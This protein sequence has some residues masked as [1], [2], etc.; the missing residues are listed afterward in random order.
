MRPRTAKV[1]FAWGRYL[2][3]DRFSSDEHYDINPVLVKVM[4]A[5]IRVGWMLR[6]LIGLWT[7]ITIGLNLQA[8]T[9][10]MDPYLKLELQASN[11]HQGFRLRWPSETGTIYQVQSAP[12]LSESNWM[13]LATPLTATDDF[14]CL[15][16]SAP[17]LPQQFYR[18]TKTARVLFQ[19]D[20]NSG[21]SD[22]WSLAPG[23]SMELDGDNSILN[24]EGHV[25]ANL[26]QTYNWN[27]FRLQF[28]L[29][30]ITGNLHVNYRSCNV[31]R[32]FVWF[33]QSGIM[34]SKQYWPDVFLN[35]LQISKTP[36]P[37]GIWQSI[38]I[39]GS[40]PNIKVLVNGETRIDF[41]D[42]SPLLNGTIAFESLSGRVQI[43]DVLVLGP[44]PLRSYPRLTWVRTGGPLG[45]IGYD[46]RIDPTNTKI[47]YVTDA[48]SGVSKSWDGGA[49]WSP[50]NDGIIS[51]GG[52]SGDAIPVFCL[53]IDPHHSQVLWIG[54][55]SMRGV[56]KST[57][58]GALWVEKDDGIADIPGITFRSF[59]VHPTNSDI[60]YLG[61]E[62]PTTNLGPDGQNLVFGKIFKT[63]DGGNHWEEILAC[64]ALVRWII[65]DPT[66]TRILYAATGIF[67]RDDVSSEGILKSTDAGHTWRAIN[68]GLG[69]LTVGALVM[70]PSDP[71][72]LYA[73]T[74]RNDGFGGGPT[75]HQGGV[76]KSIDGGE[77][78][79]KIL[80]LGDEFFVVTGLALAPSNPDFLYAAPENFTSYR[81]MDAG[82]TWQAFPFYADGTCLGAPI[83]VTF[84]P[85]DASIVYINSYVGGVF[86]SVDGGENWHIS[87]QGYTGAQIY[88]VSIDPLH[89]MTIYANGRQG[90]AK[91]LSGGA[92]WTYQN[93]N[94]ESGIFTE[95]A[96]VSVNPI[97]SQD[98]VISHRF[99]GGVY[100]SLDGGTNWQ[101]VFYE[102]LVAGQHGISHFARFQRNPKIIYGASKIAELTLTPQFTKSIGIIKSIDGGNNWSKVTN[103][104]IA[105]FNFNTVALH[106][107]NP[108][109][110]Y[111][112]AHNGGVYKTTDGGANWQ[113]VGGDFATDIRSMAVDP[114]DG[115]HIYAG[116]ERGGLFVSKNA[117]VSWN[118][119]GAGIDA[120]ASIRSIVVDPSNSEI[121]WAGD[122]FSGVYYSMDRGASWILANNGLRT[123]AVTALSISA[124]GKVLYA[125]T[126]GEGVFRLGVL[127]P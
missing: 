112:G 21:N 108:D 117:G 90:F 30:I 97:D 42:S 78:W 109:I 15:P 56:Y 89:P 75:A 96:A 1:Y 27:D 44:P 113:Q 93:R 58:G 6:W 4:K 63:M 28:R 10:P 86:K 60:V 40:G 68:Q 115:E 126:D 72:V 17:V 19:D 45:G 51:R 34:I 99:N 25:W 46:L 92:D 16:V 12:Q 54:T 82:K 66:D 110:V 102:P 52:A 37:T 8:E 88:D 84:D 70:D 3:C 39:M 55:L 71:K 116:I 103:G 74:G 57:N 2:R 120:N 94:Q 105:D 62:I 53:T 22:Q 33:D 20:F 123:R 32:Y 81:S 24:G 122:C 124:N 79:T 69:N 14:T 11:S 65:I 125:A 91:S 41:T 80:G 48:F 83:A 111:A 101:R 64:G 35:G 118:R 18:V 67:D 7:T 119:F 47:L 98:L 114:L 38:E 104:L 87:S 95:A 73:G 43:D 106:P 9:I 59:T 36:I 100:H 76:Y 121:I 23:W 107:A 127:G 26:A 31:G 50:I 49:S 61:T 5:C 29:K 85:F 77:H 13:N